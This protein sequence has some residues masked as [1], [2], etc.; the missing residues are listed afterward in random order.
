MVWWHLQRMMRSGGRARNRTDYLKQL[1]S[2]G[3]VFTE[4]NAAAA[5]L[6]HA[7]KQVPKKSK[8]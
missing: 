3:A 2:S 1:Q 6:H 7:A 4:I 5:A 8:F